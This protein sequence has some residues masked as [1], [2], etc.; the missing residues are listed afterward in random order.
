[1]SAQYAI[2]HKEESAHEEGIW[3]VAWATNPEDGSE[4]IVTGG[5]DGVVKSW[6]WQ[7]NMV[8]LE[9]AMTGHNLG[10]VGITANGKKAASVGMDATIR[11]WDLENAQELANIEGSP[12]DMWSICFSPDGTKIATG[13]TGADVKVFNE[14]H[15]LRNSLKIYD[16]ETCEEIQRVSAGGK[17]PFVLSLAYSPDGTLLAIGGMDGIITIFSTDNYDTFNVIEGHAM[18]IR[19]IAFSSDSQFMMSASDDGHIKVY[20]ASHKNLVGTLSGH[21]GWVLSVAFGPDNTA[22]SCSADKT[23]KV[24]NVGTRQC[25]HTFHDHTD[26]VWCA[27]YASDGQTVATVGDDGIL[28][29]FDCPV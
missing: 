11:L 4:R 15:S 19:S 1:M 24:W 20:D 9:H 12:S 21:S 10:I 18:P 13:A 17:C 22:V 14:K 8:V 27:K 29:V 25:L 7:N 23:V 3:C 16:A 2:L 28:H 26:M 5:A 6:K